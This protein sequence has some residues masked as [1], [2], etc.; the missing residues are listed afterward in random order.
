MLSRFDFFKLETDHLFFWLGGGADFFYQLKLDFVIDKVKVFFCVIELPTIAI[1]PYTLV[2]LQFHQISIYL[3][4]FII[5]LII[6]S[7]I[8]KKRIT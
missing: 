6:M 5:F 7:L 1:R 3:I 8:S 4:T 2:K